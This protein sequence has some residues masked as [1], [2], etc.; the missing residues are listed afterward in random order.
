MSIPSLAASKRRRYRISEVNNKAV[1]D[2]TCSVSANSG[3]TVSMIVL[4][5]ALAGL[6]FGSMRL[7]ESRTFPVMR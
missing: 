6:L 3:G 5:C 4:A 2:S 7:S 1:R